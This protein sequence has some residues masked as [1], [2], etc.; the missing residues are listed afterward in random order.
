MAQSRQGG[1]C[2]IVVFTR[3]R[4]AAISSALWRAYERAYSVPWGRDINTQRS[5]RGEDTQGAWR[6]GCA[7]R[8][9]V[10]MSMTDNV[11]PSH[12]S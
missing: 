5:F 12:Q 2:G 3:S 4:G 10:E 6:P 9:E 11:T 8:P 1:Y 7:E